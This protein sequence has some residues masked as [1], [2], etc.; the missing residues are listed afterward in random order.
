[1]NVTF[2]G[3]RGSIAAPGQDTMRYG[4]NT[5]CVEVRSRYDDILVLDA[6]TGLRPLGARLAAL[7][8]T[9]GAPRRI[10][11]LLTHLHMDHLQGLGF[12]MPLYMPEFEIHIW[13]PA[14]TT[15]GLEVRLSRYLSPP[16]F[17][18]RLA[19]LPRKPVLHDV[20]RGR[21]DIGGFTLESCLVCHPGPTAAYRI[22]EDNVSMAYIPDHEPAEYPNFVGWGH[23][24]ISQTLHF[25]ELANAGRLVMFHHDP[26]R[27]DDGLDQMLARAREQSP[28]RPVFMAAEGVEIRLR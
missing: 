9:G 15:Q 7:H 18:V 14:S 8:K 1:M 25:A 6:G 13:G 21:W 11:L 22:S 26:A 17:P 28:V 23:S 12:F 16:L 20:P 2:W 10:D 27:T 4:G 19:D 3:T 24:S 5:S